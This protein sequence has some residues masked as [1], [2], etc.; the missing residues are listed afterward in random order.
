MRGPLGAHRKSSGLIVHPCLYGLLVLVGPGLLGCDKRDHY[1]KAPGSGRE[2]P[3]V[4]GAV[5]D[6]HGRVMRGAL[7]V[8]GVHVLARVTYG[9]PCRASNPAP[10]GTVWSTTPTDSTGRFRTTA[11]PAAGAERQAGCLF[12]GATDPVRAETTWAAPRPAP[13][14]VQ[15]ASTTRFPVVEIDV[16]WPE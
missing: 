15:G 7:P 3:I 5:A 16:P 2:P 6:I 4:P 11:Y 13:A 9:A 12:V 1:S 8:S 10:G 14:S